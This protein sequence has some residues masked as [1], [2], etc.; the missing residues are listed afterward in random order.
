MIF[1]K[2]K[3]QNI[4]ILSILLL[5]ISSFI[6]IS[7][8]SSVSSP[9]L[10]INYRHDSSQFE[11]IGKGWANGLL[12]YRD[13]WDSKGPYV[14][15]I[16]MIAYTFNGKFTLWLLEIFNLWITNIFC[17]KAA[18]LKFN[19]KISCL[20]SAA[21]CFL[22]MGYFWYFGNN[23]GE[24]CLPFLSLAHYGIYKYL[25][26]GNKELPIINGFY[27]GMAAGI[28]L[29]TRATNILG[30]AFSI[31]FGFFILLKNKQFKN[32]L[33]NI[34][35]GLLGISIITVP[36]FLYF[37]LH[38]ILQ[39]M[40]F[41]T[42]TY[43]TM[44]IE[45]WQNN[46]ILSSI[47]V[48]FK[49]NIYLLFPIYVFYRNLKKKNWKNIFLIILPLFLT[50]AFILLKTR[51]FR[52]YFI[53][54]YPLLF[55]TFIEFFNLKNN[56]IL[57]ILAGFIILMSLTVNM[58][59]SPLFLN[60]NAGKNSGEIAQKY[61]K[62][63]PDNATFL[64]INRINQNEIYLKNNILPNNRFFLY[65]DAAAAVGEEIREMVH[66]DL[67]KNE[68]DYIIYSEMNITLTNIPSWDKSVY[69]DILE[70]DYTILK[71][72]A[73]SD[74]RNILLFKRKGI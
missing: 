3:I 55:I 10:G 57:K 6:F 13:L 39:D 31:L 16:N 47:G 35:T 20:L 21:G 29:M 46:N 19:Q 26:S 44:Y 24:W 33:Q 2:R 9:F 53:I 61:M 59:I 63:I 50:I 42:F 70:N 34:L 7:I 43:N 49:Y 48:L 52:N 15:F 5:L 18:R 1:L 38:G 66:N 11:T 4:D 67:S 8:F 23:Q 17:Y 12:P 22:F 65:Q 73:L 27:C 32:L 45:K 56:L 72:T 54:L 69:A 64:C 37:Y 60:M 68:P 28:S 36:F 25:L 14:F 40:L 41:A 58:L 71:T 62:M 51:G 74:N 30:V